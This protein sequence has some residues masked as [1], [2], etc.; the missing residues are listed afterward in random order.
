VGVLQAGSQISPGPL[1]IG[2]VDLFKVVDG[3]QKKKDR[4][5][6]LNKARDAAAAQLKE[7]QKKIEGMASELELVDKSSPDY[8]AKKRTLS[9]KQEE[10]LMRSRLA[11]RE[12]MGKLEQYLQEVYSEVLAKIAEYREKNNFDFILRADTRPLTTQERII[13]QLDRK[14]IM[15]SSKAFDVSDD[16]IAFLNQSYTK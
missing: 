9:E 2:V 6:E 15:A 16:V 8:P 7:L 5:V 1:K 13:D 3:Y 11:E 12:V 10:L 4:E 14:V